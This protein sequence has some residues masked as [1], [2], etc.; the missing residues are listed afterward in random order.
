MWY[1]L[2]F[3]CLSILENNVARHFIENKL[4]SEPHGQWGSLREMF[5]ILQGFKVKNSWRAPKRN[6]QHNKHWEILSYP[7]VLGGRRRSWSARPDRR[8]GCIFGGARRARRCMFGGGGR[9]PR[10]ADAPEQQ[11][12][13]TNAAGGRSRR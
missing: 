4:K 3:L 1:A 6:S 9:R 13:S 7:L 12:H 5:E 8:R 10:R 2:L 11:P